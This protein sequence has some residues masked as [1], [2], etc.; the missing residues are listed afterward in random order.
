MGIVETKPLGEGSGGYGISV[1]VLDTRFLNSRFSAASL[2]HTCNGGSSSIAQSQCKGQSTGPQRWLAARRHH[3]WAMR[4]RWG[5]FRYAELGESFT[6]TLTVVLEWLQ[7]VFLVE[8]VSVLGRFLS[9][10]SPGTVFPLWSH[11]RNRV[12]CERKTSRK[13]WTRLQSGPEAQNIRAEAP[14]SLLLAPEVSGMQTPAN[15]TPSRSDASLH[16]QRHTTKC[17]HSTAA[18]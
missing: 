14:A 17:R 9:S 15:S 13:A 5:R 10:G 8:L 18:T 2:L 1:L 7:R 16:H 12:S 11:V 3:G 4:G 6:S